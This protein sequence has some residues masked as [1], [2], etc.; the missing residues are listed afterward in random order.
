MSRRNA[1]LVTFVTWCLCVP[2]RVGAVTIV[3]ERDSTGE[4]E[5]RLLQSM[6][7]RS[8]RVQLVRIM[9]ALS[10]AVH[11]LAGF[12]PFSIAGPPPLRDQVSL[13]GTWNF[14]PQDG[15]RSSISVPEFWDAAPGFECEQA[16]T[17][18]TKRPGAAT[19]ASYRSNIVGPLPVGRSLLARKTSFRAFVE[20]SQSWTKVPVCPTGW[21]SESKSEDRR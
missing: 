4:M 3:V 9:P 15:E 18:C 7:A 13:K 10:I 21:T 17:K 14:T 19:K 20:Q 1:F 2:V 8:V 16:G 5:M 12:V 11:L 6:D